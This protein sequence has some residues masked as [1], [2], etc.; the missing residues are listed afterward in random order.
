MRSERGRRS[1]HIVEFNASTPVLMEARYVDSPVRLSPCLFV[2][3]SFVHHPKGAGQ[4]CA[5]RLG[6]R[7]LTRRQ[8]HL[9]YEIITQRGEG[10]KAGRQRNSGPPHLLNRLLAAA[11]IVSSRQGP[12]FFQAQLRRG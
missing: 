11:K 4:M 5:Q 8:R 12:C 6:S 1:Q 9:T 10:K 3:H 2:P 7:L